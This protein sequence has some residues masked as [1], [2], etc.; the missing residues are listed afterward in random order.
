MKFNATVLSIAATLALAACGGSGGGDSVTTNSHNTLPVRQIDPANAD[1]ATYQRTQDTTIYSVV[2]NSNSVAST[3][4]RLDRMMAEG[5]IS[6]TNIERGRTGAGNLVEDPQLTAYAQ[7]RA[8]EIAYDFE[9][10]R[11]GNAAWHSSLTGYGRV[12]GGENLASHQND[13]QSVITD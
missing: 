8:E 3:D 6:A 1:K 11:P 2:A 4:N 7:R 9:H 10:R 13:A 5:V 12:G